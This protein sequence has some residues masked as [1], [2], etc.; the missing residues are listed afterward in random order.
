MEPKGTSLMSQSP[1]YFSIMRGPFK[2]DSGKR[3]EALT[4]FEKVK[5]T[6]GPSEWSEG[7]VKRRAEFND[8]RRT[9]AR[10]SNRPGERDQ[11]AGIR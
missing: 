5:E 3:W 2:T 9:Q 1:T 10:K 4:F 11:A 6:F 8:W 7:A